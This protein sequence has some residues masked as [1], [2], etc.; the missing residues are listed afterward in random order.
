MIQRDGWDRRQ[1]DPIIL[2]SLVYCILLLWTIE[3]SALADFSG[4]L[5][6]LLQNHTVSACDGDRLMLQC[7]R[8]S[9]VSVQSAFYGHP[10]PGLPNC[11]SLSPETVHGTSGGCMALTALQKVLDECQNLRSCQLLV[12]SRVFGA[13]PCPGVKKHLLVSYKCKPT[14]YK[15]T[16][17]CENTELKLHC[18]EPKLLNIY[19]A[20]YG[21]LAHEKNMCPTETDRRTPYDCLSY[22]ALEVLAQRCYGKQRCKMAVND[23]NFGRP[24]LPGVQKYLTVN[25][26]CVPKVILTEVDPKVSSLIPSFKQNDGEYD[27]K[28]KPRESRLP[29][30]EGIT[31]SNLLAAFSYVKDHPESAALYFISSVCIGLLFTLFALVIRISRR[32][33][34]RKAPKMN[35]HVLREKDHEESEGSSTEE[36]GSTKS[37]FSEEFR[38]LC[39]V[40]RPLYN[41]IDEADLAER[42]E[43]R[44]QI[45][46]EIW[47][48]SGLDLPPSRLTNPYF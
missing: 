16:S 29:S 48:N 39:K 23:D 38:E 17:V 47:M 31:L 7:P 27:I 30:R 22:S 45:I 20:V 6:K 18:K 13:D 33:D 34:R 37:H 41:P 43:R 3:V 36:E 40:S 42:I 1:V 28:L 15:S 4:Y 21:R 44:E 12:N 35:G 25:Y 32:T 14:E 46:Q 24:C 11:A 8:H 26:S 9:T 10:A 19:S 5:T 2:T